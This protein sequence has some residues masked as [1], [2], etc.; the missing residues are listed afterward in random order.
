M[1]NLDDVRYMLVAT[2]LIFT[3]LFFFLICSY[4]IVTGKLRYCIDTA[5]L[6]EV[7]KDCPTISKPVWLHGT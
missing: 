4:V 1:K 6:S 2:P 5:M 3:T 7:G